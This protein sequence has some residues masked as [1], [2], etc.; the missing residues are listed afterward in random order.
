MKA[1]ANKIAFFCFH[2]F[3]RIEAFQGVT[4]DS[5]KKTGAARDSRGGLWSGTFQTAMGFFIF[6]LGCGPSEDKFREQESV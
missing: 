2:L 5:N 3:F 4:A 6:P 1:N